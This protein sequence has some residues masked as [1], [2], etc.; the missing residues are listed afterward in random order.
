MKRFLKITGISILVLL[1]LLITLPYLFRG[2]I[3]EAIKTAANDNLEATIDFSSVGIS[4]IRNFP[5][6]RVSM[7]EFTVNN[8]GTFDGVQLARI[9]RLEA[10]ID[11]KSV[12]GDQ[13][14]IRRIA[15]IE[16]SFDVRVNAEGL[17]NYDITKADTT[18][19]VE[20]VSPEVADESSPLRLRV[21][22]VT[23]E[24]LNLRYE[25]LTMPMRMTINDLGF[26]ASGGLDGDLTSWKATSFAEKA[27]VVMDGI[28]YLKD[29]A[30]K[31]NAE[32][33]ADLKNSKYTL[34]DNSVSLNALELRADGWV[35]MPSD[36]IDMDL[37]FGATKTDFI[38]LLSLVPREFAGD[39]KGVEASGK[40]GVDGYVKGTYNDSRMPVVGIDLFVENGRFKYPELPKSVDNVQVKMKAVADLTVMDRT[41]LD[42]E[43]FH[44]EMGGN[45]V[46]LRLMLRTPESDPDI[47]FTCK[48]F[49]DLDNVGEFIPLEGGGQV[50]GQIN[51]DIA[52]AGRMSSIEK[53][54]YDQFKAE[55]ILGIRN[56]LFRSDSLPYDLQ[57][58]S[59]DFNFT[60]AFVSL[61]NFSAQIGKSDLSASGRITDYLNYVLRDSLL[62]GRFSVS[63]KLLDLNEFMS[64]EE[65]SSTSSSANTESEEAPL[66][67]IE[68]PGNVD[69]ALNAS[70]A[71]MIYGDNV[72]TDV[73]GGVGL[74]DKQAFLKDLR[75]NVLEGSVGMSGTYDARDLNK[76]IIDLEFD[77][78]EMDINKSAIQFATID[79]MAPIAK[80]CNGR[81]SARFSMKCDLQPDMM[82]INP[83]V[84]GSG[85][86]STKSVTVKDFEPL[87]KL[88]DKINYEKL[89]QALVVNDINVAFK[90]VKGVI[91][92]EPFTVKLDG[93]PA[94][95]YGST[96]LDQE[97][98]YNL[99]M[100][101]PLDR[102]PSSALNQAT[103]FIGEINKKLGS[104]LSVGSKVN[105]IARITGTVTDPKI[106]VTSKALGADAVKDLKEQA[107]ES[108]KEEVKEKITDLRNEALEKAIAEKERLVKEAQAAADKAKRDGREAAQRVKDE[109]YKLAQQTEDSAKNPLEKQAKKLA[110]DKI[111][112][113]A[114]EAYTK[115]VAEAEKRANNL[116]KDAEARGDKLIEDANA[117]SDTQINKID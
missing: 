40:I 33:E 88:A 59:A 10:V 34:R 21:E 5:N 7:D 73:K 70:V 106:G 25:D 1:I 92:V 62:T 18:A 95:I 109:A 87:V 115:A 3:V 60:P 37:T 93:V 99:E 67:A 107:I 80:A 97:I 46:D 55:G 114:D 79:K 8:V 38:H 81:F 104:N 117:K 52:L 2:K 102:F 22:D 27:T 108:I 24:R 4:L 91:T 36:D 65:T 29:V 45:P 63:S 77:I 54:R 41:T 17:A 90:I 51:A 31:F 53:E 96:T 83:S 78:R 86:L 47:D 49:I 43:L 100:D 56:V 64:E 111:R 14:M 116:V 112:K 110:A 85:S 42:V 89:K 113:E 72:L 66:S 28:T 103:S 6:L 50:H 44:L 20:P 71:K 12:F 105:V 9:G 69:F 13:I 76:P 32:I 11:I 35:S 74:R 61:D 26:K 58:N 19:A 84:N 75:M 30:L 48:A 101:V 23:I 16:P 15:L 57:V 82:P 94:K 39:L 68:L 98:D